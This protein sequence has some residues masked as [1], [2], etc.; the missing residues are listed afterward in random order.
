MISLVPASARTNHVENV[1]HGTTTTQGRVQD[2]ALSARGARQRVYYYWIY[3]VNTIHIDYF[4]MNN[5][6]VVYVSYYKYDACV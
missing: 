3:V 5:I 1:T 4:L 2:A 6:Y